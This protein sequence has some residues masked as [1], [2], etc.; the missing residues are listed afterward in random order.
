MSSLTVTV[1]DKMGLTGA[2]RIS[3]ASSYA[4]V[5]NAK[6]VADWLKDHSD[7]Q[8]ISYGATTDF[9]GDE[10]DNG[11]YDRVQQRLTMLFTD[12]N[13]SHRFGIPAPK[14][15][16]LDDDQQPISDLPEDVKDLLVSVGAMDSATYT[17][18]GGGLQS[19]LPD[20]RARKRAVT[21]V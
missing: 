3:T 9:I 8:V 12:K 21:G 11:K 14:D 16:D 15:E 2:V 19:R 5:A 1:K 20:S 10:C 13:G 4:T 6:K 18:G 17:Y 7:A